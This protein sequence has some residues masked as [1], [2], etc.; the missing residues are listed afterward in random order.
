MGEPKKEKEEKA[1]EPEKKEDEAKK[2]DKKDDKKEEDKKDEAKD[3]DKKEDEPTPS[4]IA[5]FEE[6]LKQVDGALKEEDAP[7]DEIEAGGKK[8][9]SSPFAAC[10]SFFSKKKK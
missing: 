4:E 7:K 10:A 9:P 6:T 2:D 3:D 1:D 8:E 5:E